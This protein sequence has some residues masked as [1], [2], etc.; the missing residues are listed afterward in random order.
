ME[1]ILHNSKEEAALLQGSSL[2]QKNNVPHHNAET[3]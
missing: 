1:P 3:V 2:L